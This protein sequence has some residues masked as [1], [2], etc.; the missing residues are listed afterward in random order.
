M[1][2]EIYAQYYDELKIVL[3]RLNRLYAITLDIKTRVKNVACT[4][5]KLYELKVINIFD[6]LNFDFRCSPRVKS[7]SL[8]N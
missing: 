7:V 2:A 4:L 8:S 5:E 1:L 3:H 6:A